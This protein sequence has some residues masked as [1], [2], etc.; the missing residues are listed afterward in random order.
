MNM[1]ISTRNPYTGEQVGSYKMDSFK[2]ATEKII[3]IRKHQKKWAEDIDQRIDFFKDTIRGN[4]ERE[5]ENLARLMTEEM[6]KPISQSISEVKKSIK[7]IDYL[8]ENA[9]SIFSPENIKTE[10]SRSYVRFDPLGIMMAIEPWNFPVW[11]V[12]RAVFPAL[13]AGNGAVLKHASIVTGVSLKIEELIDLPVFRSLVID[14]NT[15][16]SLI[17]QVEGIAFTGSTP[18]GSGIASVAGRELKKVVMELGGSDPFIVLNSASIDDAAKNAT[19]GRLQNNGQSCIASKRFIIHADVY[20]EFKEKMEKEF[21]RVKVGDPMKKDTYLGPLSSGSQKDTV[22]EQIEFLSKRGKITF[23]GK[24]EGNIIPPTIVEYGENYQEEVFGPVAI[25]KKFSTESEAI[26]MANESP[27]GLGTSIWGRSDEAE[28]LV[29][30]IEAGMVFINSIVFSDPR[31]PFGGIKKSGL[32]RELS[33]YGSREF[34]NM[35]TV[36]IS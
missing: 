22:K 20:D 11:Q 36:W 33:K 25:L 6:G 14:G 35:K 29:P 27:F 12:A 1:E 7:L 13:I 5:S 21:S 4:F 15:A 23:F 24:E 18:T 17:G 16:T 2:D 3:Q 9:Q 8:I 32:G 19:F 34:T 10:A 31:L 26:S 30:S 28:R